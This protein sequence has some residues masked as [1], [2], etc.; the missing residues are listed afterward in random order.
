MR[1]VPLS[2]GLA[3]QIDG[4]TPSKLGEASA[5]SRGA[6]VIAVSHLQGGASAKPKSSILSSAESI[7]SCH[8]SQRARQRSAGRKRCRLK[9]CLRC[10]ARPLG[11]SS[12]AHKSDFGDSPKHCFCGA[13]GPK[14]WPRAPAPRPAS[15]GARRAAARGRRRATARRRAAGRA[16]GPSRSPTRGK[17]GDGTG[18]RVTGTACRWNDRGF[19]FI[20]PARFTASCIQ[21]GCSS[22]AERPLCM[23]KAQGSNPCS[24]TNTHLTPWRNG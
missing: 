3:G 1:S 15:T 18:E 5:S 8:P 16:R 21:R 10:A 2:A 22:V 13:R 23:R 17:I 7:S 6:S 11:A 24:S 20:K 9:S 14:P 12:A 19:G 4:F